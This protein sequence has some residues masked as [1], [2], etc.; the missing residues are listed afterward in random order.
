MELVVA[1]IVTSESLLEFLLLFQSIQRF[2]NCCW[3]VVTDESSADY[4]CH[5]DNLNVVGIHSAESSS[6]GNS[7]HQLN[8]AH[9]RLMMRKFDVCRSALQYHNHVLFLDSDIFFLSSLENHI[10][11]DIYSNPN[12]AA[13]VSPHLSSILI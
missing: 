13:I 3:Y 12:I 2:H 4:L 11:S 5:F 10:L 7:D 1:T 9:M 6:H 8:A